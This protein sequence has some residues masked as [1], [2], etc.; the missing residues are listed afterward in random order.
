MAIFRGASLLLGGREVEGGKQQYYWGLVEKNVLVTGSEGQLGSELKQLSER[1][2]LPFRFHFRD[3]EALDITNIGQVDEYLRSNNI[4]YIINAAAYTNVDKAET[5]P[6]NAFAVNATAVGNIA[7][8][9]KEYEIKLIH[10]STD[11]L[12]DGNSSIPYR[13]DMQTNPLSIYAKSKQQGEVA[14]QQFGK[15]WIII[16]TG[17]LYS[18]Y[19]NN[20]LKT[21]LRLMKERER[22]SV[23]DDEWG[24]PTYTADLAEMIIHILRF[25]EENKWKTGIYH[26]ANSG[27]ASR[28]Q[29]ANEIKKLAGIEKC[30]L[31]PITAKEYRSPAL[32]PS[33]SVL[34]S[35]KISTVFQVEI[36]SWREALKRCIEK[37]NIES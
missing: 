16:R 6:E 32:R 4:Q 27:E 17:W 35:T 18:Q 21:M 14:L 10:I 36:P 3:R 8:I 11:Y 33:Y 31:L 19:G 1:V 26:F 23:V 24:G 37:L 28:Y 29:F 12:F 5:E 9:A 2:N 34:D 25:S 22:L 15:D 30:E 13:E 20:F 7:R